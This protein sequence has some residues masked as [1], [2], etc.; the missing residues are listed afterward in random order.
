MDVKEHVVAH[1]ELKKLRKPI[2]NV[3]IKHKESCQEHL[4][5]K[6]HSFYIVEF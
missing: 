3:N 4:F 6:D 1:E 5:P 2:H